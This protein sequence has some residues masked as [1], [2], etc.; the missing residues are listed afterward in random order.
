MG[1]ERKGQSDNAGLEK[2]KSISGKQQAYGHSNTV[3]KRKAYAI[4]HPTGGELS[5]LLPIPPLSLR[6]N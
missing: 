1:G 4:I 2:K 6:Q 3:V 5:F